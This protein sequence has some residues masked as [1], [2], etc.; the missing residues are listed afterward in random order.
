MSS[1]GSLY[2]IL[3]TDSTATATDIKSAYRAA[4]KRAHPDAGGSAEAMARVNEAYQILSDPEAR[5]AYDESEKAVPTPESYDETRPVEHTRAYDA[6]AAQAEADAINRGRVVWARRSAWNLLRTS[7]P[8]AIGAIVVT[9]LA[10]VYLA[11]IQAYYVLAAVGFLPVYALIL[12][13]IF[14][15]DPPLRLIFADL[16]RRYPTDLSEKAAAAGII[17]AFFPLALLWVLWR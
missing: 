2:R 15:Y 12:S 11:N 8:Y 3:G 9:R 13:I 7:A 17:L 5:R 6:A 1:A 16:A 14:I 4:A 10:A